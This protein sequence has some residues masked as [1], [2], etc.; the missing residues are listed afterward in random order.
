M[1]A[2]TYRL[3]LPVLEHALGEVLVVPREGDFAVVALMLNGRATDT[4]RAANKAF[5]LR[6][7]GFFVLL[8]HDDL[9]LQVGEAVG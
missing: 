9:L 4:E 5:R 1:K 2:K 6:V 3:V 8:A 7:E